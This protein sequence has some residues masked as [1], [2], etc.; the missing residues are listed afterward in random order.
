MTTLEQLCSSALANPAAQPALEFEHE[1][2]AWG[3][4]HRVA[5]E[6]DAALSASGA[7]GGR[8][9]FVAR[10]RPSAIA[11][12]LGLLARRSPIRMVYP[13]QSGPALAGDLERI[14]PAAVVAAQEDFSEAVAAL[15]AREG[16]AAVGLTEMGAT[17]LP[18]LE[19]CRALPADQA[20]PEPLVEILTSGTTGPPKPFPLDYGFIAREIVA[21]SNLPPELKGSGL[22]LPPALLMFPVSNISGLYSTLP[23]LLG[24]Q[25]IVLLERFTAEGWHDHLVRFRPR[26]GGM[27]PAG[28]QMVLDADIPPEDLACLQALGT[29]AAP[30]DPG[31]KQAFEER[32]GVPILLSYGATEFGGPVAR[33]TP[34]LIA[35]WGN[36]KAASV[37]PA[38]PGARLRVVD[39]DTGMELARG[40]EGLLEVVSPRIGPEWIRTSDLAVIDRDGFLYIRG[41]ADGAIMRGGFKLLPSVIENALLQHPLV[42]HA[43]VVGIPDRRLGQVPAAAVECRPGT[44][45]PSPEELEAHLRDR[46]P[47]THIPTAWRLVDALPRTPSMKVDL[48][49]V[50]RLFE[51]DREPG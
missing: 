20:S 16:I 31:V 36:E 8:V 5:G 22:D 43:A 15:L 29:G 11:A 47:A 49:A 50:R 26:F 35:Q 48:P 51:P 45:H 13:F 19:H 7:A 41:R 30:L 12:L 2:F 24:G 14:K 1:W 25:R 9:A 10:N 33:M 4:M 27:P 34:E 21:N 17:A 38:M 42:S 28:V 18:G 23:P 39:P 46:V 44:A 37:G 40:E 3:A 32:Y 6:L